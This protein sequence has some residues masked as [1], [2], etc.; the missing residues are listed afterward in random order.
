MN[1]CSYCNQSLDSKQQHNKCELCVRY[2]KEV[3]HDIDFSNNVSEEDNINKIRF[4]VEGIKCISCV[5]KIESILQAREVVSYCRVNMT[6]SRLTI[7]WN[8]NKELVNLFAFLV[9]EAGF[10]VK[11]FNNNQS[12][13]S[14]GQNELL[15][16]L[17]IAGFCLGNVMLLS[18]ILWFTDTE[19]ISYTTRKIFQ[20][21]SMLLSIP[22]V[23]YSGQYFFKSAFN[24]IKQFKS[25]I[26]IPIS[27][28]IIMTTVMSINQVI[29]NAEHIYFESVLMLIFFLLIGRYYNASSLQKARSI[30]DQLLMQLDNKN[31]KLITEDN[32]CITVPVRDLVAGNKIIIAKGDIVPTDCRVIKGNSDIDMSVI[33]G[34]TMPKRVKIDDQIFAGVINLTDSLVCIVEQNYGNS[35]LNNMLKIIEDSMNSKSRYVELAGKISQYYTPIVHIIS[36]AGLLY[37]WLF[38]DIGLYHSIMIALTILIITCPCALGLAVPLVQVLASNFLMDKGIIIKNVL[39]LERITNIDNIVFDKTGT[40][41]YGVPKLYGGNYTDDD[42][43]LASSLAINSNHPLSKA[44]TTSYSDKLV[45]IS[46]IEEL[47]GYGIQGK[48][49]GDNLFLG[50]RKDQDDN[51]NILQ[52]NLYINENKKATFLFQD[53]LRDGIDQ[54]IAYIKKSNVNTVLL[55]GDKDSIVSEVA[56]KLN[57]DQYYAG[58]DPMQKSTLIQELQQGNKTVLMLGDGI[59]DTAALALADVSVSH[60]EAVDITQNIADIVFQDSN[61]MYPLQDILISSYTFIKL[62]KQN[63]F[64]S[65]AYNMCFIPLAF[66]GLVTP[67]WAALFMSI[68]SISVTLNSF[69]FMKLTKMNTK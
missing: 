36:L 4:L 48:Y 64:I 34:E 3:N 29:I 19:S 55:S 42:L 6:M 27:V 38:T 2:E 63:I 18:F 47:A 43:K 24:S 56:E 61:S 54:V 45:E 44:I 17:A 16:K 1:K 23:I 35:I 12:G 37:W 22:A 57:F 40:I 41:T 31:V 32:N 62:V 49:E 10:K 33:N 50:R 30:A 39:S 46:K 66:M 53:R 52:V 28:A 14:S 69:R 9:I 65:L 20:W 8:G 60:S 51:D 68:S 25:N 67:L 11:L 15:K 59:N 13:K 21:L 7:Y 26:D 58:Y 5:K